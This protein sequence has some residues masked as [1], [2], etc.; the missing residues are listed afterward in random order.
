VDFA[1][2]IMEYCDSRVT[3]FGVTSLEERFMDL[4]KRYDHKGGDTPQRRAYESAVRSMEKQIFVKCKIKPEDI[5]DESI[6]PIFFK[7]KEFVV[8]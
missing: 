8:K 7:L 6:K 2:K 1:S 4:R 3:P 5:N